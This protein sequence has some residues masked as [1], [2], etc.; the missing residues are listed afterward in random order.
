MVARY[1]V[2]VLGA[3]AAGMMCAVRAGQRGRSVVVLDHAAAPGEK[4]R[5]SGGGRCNF[6]NIHAGP[7]NFLSANQHF[8][9]SALA[10]FTPQDFIAI[11][12]RHGIAWH[13]KTLGQLFCDNSAKDI[14][15]MLTDEMRAAGAQLRLRTEVGG[16]EQSDGGYRISTSE[17][18]F[19]A[20]SLVVATG[21]KSIPKMGATGFAYRLAEQFDLPIVETR[22][23]LV[24]LTLDPQLLQHL[25]PLSGIAVPAEIRHGKTAFR[26]ALLFTHRGLSGPAILQISSYW[27]EGEDISVV[28]EPDIDLFE[29]LKKAKQVNGRQSAQTALAEILPKRLAQ[30]FVENEGISG[31]MADQSDKRLQQLASA[32]QSWSVKPSGSEGYRTAEVTLGG[33]DTDCLDSRTMQVKTVP[34]LFFIGECVDVTGWLGGYNFQWA[35]ASGH[36]AGEAA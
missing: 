2:I 28:I 34:G 26:E 27:R 8:A 16:I 29:L 18:I 36:V 7:K 14:I 21:G 1:D 6:T 5:I 3:G 31:N 12:E 25:A 11:V 19:E 4:I 35:W 30:H 23:G 15:R 22:P 13:E 32:I 33:I 10:R 9:K 20:T 17:G 24:P